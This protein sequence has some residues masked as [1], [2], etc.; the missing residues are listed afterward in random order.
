MENKKKGSEKRTVP[1]LKREIIVH[2]KVKQLP[3]GKRASTSLLQHADM[4]RTKNLSEGGIFFTA[5]RA[6]FPGTILA[7]KL[8][9]PLFRKVIELQARV[10]GSEEVANNLIYNT[11][12]EFINMQEEQNR[13]LKEFINL[14][15]KG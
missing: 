7:I 1:R 6:L 10:V 14:F 12:A 11:R 15:L 8:Q 3:S 9:L 13:A 4:S 2:Y 5:S